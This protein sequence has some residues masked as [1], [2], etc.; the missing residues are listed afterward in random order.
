MDLDVE[1]II[2][3]VINMLI[4]GGVLYIRKLCKDL[5]ASFRKVR[6]LEERVSK[7]EKE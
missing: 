4:G 7:L 3:N 2:S 5:N 6:L 1:K